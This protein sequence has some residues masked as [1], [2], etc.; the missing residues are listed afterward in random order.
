MTV[1][2]TELLDLTATLRRA[3]DSDADRFQPDT[4]WRAHWP[5]LAGLGVTALC[6]PEEHGG[7]GSEVAAALVTARELGYV[8]HG[9]PYAA[10]TAAAYALS[11]WLPA[12]R[13]EVLDEVCTG[14]HVPS[15]AL[16]ETD[17][18][19][20]EQDGKPRVEGVTRLVAGAAEADS[21]LLL[22]SHG[23][24]MYFIPRAGFD[25]RDAAPPFDV[26]RLVGDVVFASAEA[27]PVVA[28]PGGRR[29]VELLHGL[30]LSG[31][32]LGGLDRMLGRTVGHARDRVAFGKPIG[33]FQAVQHRL[34]DHTLR[35]RGWSLLAAEAA[36]RLSADG[37]TEPAAR[38]ALAA[39]AAVARGAVP[40]LHDLLQ[41]TGGSGFTWEY[42]L[43]HY[44]RRAHLNAR[45][46]RSPRRALAALADAEDRAAATAA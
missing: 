6:V 18:S 11:R 25:V 17:A 38:Q 4:D 19:V 2:P 46:S 20:A 16:L 43:H 41:L 35:L 12:D 23:D 45:L 28:E 7:F 36:E 29:F 21:V 22:P 14:A 5:G 10:V 37:A 3:L 13:R 24:T 44:E 8:L 40:M 34:V 32:S 27:V 31:D 26:S 42:G 1:S 30:L 33:A 15:L 9:S 39:E